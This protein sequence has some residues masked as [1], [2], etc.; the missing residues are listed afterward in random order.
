M[1]IKL[2]G[3]PEV[4]MSN[5]ESRHNYFGWPTIIKL[6]NGRIAVG[7][8][9]FRLDHVCPFGKGVLS[10]S[11]DE[12]KSFSSPVPI[13]DTVLDD[14]DVGL[15]PFGKSG[16][17]VTSF[18]NTREMQRDH[19]NEQDEKIK[20]YIYSYLD[21]ITDEEEEKALGAEFRI[22]FDNG[23]TFGKIY[24]SPV[25]SPH[26]PIELKDGSILWVG[27][28]FRKNDVFTNIDEYIAA[29]KLDTESGSMNYIGRVPDI[30]ENGKKLQFSEPYAF[31]LNDGTIICHL[32]SETNFTLYQTVSKDNGKI[33]SVPEKLLPDNGGAPAHIIEHSSGTLISLYSFRQEPFEI[34]AMFSEDN[35]KTWDKDYTLYVNGV[36]DDLG[37]PSTTELSDGSLLTVFY[38]KETEDSPC[39]IMS[40]KWDIIL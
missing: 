20:N 31:Q 38:A 28:S 7:A 16:L 37:Y 26:G 33:W 14:R 11:D 10:F 4:I 25:T 39:V 1:K 40:Q 6:Q 15:C 30:F 5:S 24:K 23:I 9:G 32:R 27:A 12:G 22:S 29:Y 3:E 21:I 18:N 19:A 35:G 34:R 2:I 17:I 8:S 36:S 13:I